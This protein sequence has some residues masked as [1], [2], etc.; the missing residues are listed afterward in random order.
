[1]LLLSGVAEPE[2][3]F[4][5]I[6]RWP[7]RR[8][9]PRTEAW[10]IVP[11]LAVEILSLTN[12]AEQVAEKIEDYFRSGVRQV[13]IVYPGTSK[14]YL[15]NTPTGVRILQVGDDLDGGSVLG[16]FQVALDM[17][18]RALSKYDFCFVGMGFPE[19][20]SLGMEANGVGSKRI[21]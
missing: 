16:G 15:Y 13:W 14:I 11:D 21:L 2:A 1:M 12:T 7:L 18:F 6:E 10:E 17:A 9:V 4:V 3:A 19:V 5:S 20:G 8:R